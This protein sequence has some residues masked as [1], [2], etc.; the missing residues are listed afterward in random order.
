MTTGIS[1]FAAIAV[2]AAGILTAQSAAA[3]VLI[4]ST[5][6]QDDWI[7]PGNWV[8]GNTPDTVGEDARLTSGMIVTAGNFSI[9]GLESLSPHS[10]FVG[11][12]GS[13]AGTLRL[14]GISGSVGAGTA[15]FDTSTVAEL[16]V[17]GGGAFT[18]T[19]GVFTNAGSSTLAI[20]RVIVDGTG[21]LRNLANASGRMDLGSAQHVIRDSGRMDNTGILDLAGRLALRD[22]SEL[23]N[24]S[25]GS[26]SK[27][28]N[29]LF[30][31]IN[32]SKFRNEGS[33]THSAGEILSSQ[34]GQILNS[35]TFSKTGGDL[36]LEGSSLFDNTGNFTQTSG[37]TDIGNSISASSNT[38][39]NIGNYNH[40]G[41]TTNINNGATL[42]NDFLY[43]HNDGALTVRA[44]GQFTNGLI[45]TFN[46]GT[47][48]VSAGG[49]LNGTGSTSLNGGT[50]VVNGL[51][52]Q[53]GV[54]ITGGTLQGSGTV[55]ANINNTGGTV[56]PG[57]SPGT[58]TVDGNFTQGPGGTLAMEIDSLL[59]FDVLDISGSAALAGILDLT[60]DAGYAATA[61]DG[62]MFTI[63]E[64]DSFS[65]AFD[66]VTGLNFATGK[67]FTL[68]YGATGLT[69]TVNAETVVAA[70]EPGMIA[71]FGL[72]LAGIGFVRRRR[73]LR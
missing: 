35:G 11:T 25:T 46:G 42:L 21:F 30:L 63:V 1:R 12:S 27:S 51:M 15:A 66:T 10:L 34:S 31:V 71:L 41:G 36:N 50:L 7:T 67:F 70:S 13:N 73:Q 16:R 65:G 69:L 48:E 58:L 24:N 26:F 28:S 56:G 59:S 39:N 55:R 60:V 61:Q 29:D 17:R 2:V 64:W 3:G 18:T 47:V 4:T 33:Y 8:G 6:F 72:G 38:F 20:G 57:N 43:T 14:N 23:L 37:N 19:G 54:T 9:G 40:N 5:P 68:D 22:N 52:V 49:T 32:S 62:D 44:G 45:N 53:S